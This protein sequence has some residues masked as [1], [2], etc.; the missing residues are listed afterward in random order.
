MS[1]TVALVLAVIVTAAAGAADPPGGAP[2]FGLPADLRLDLSPDGTAVGAG[3]DAEWAG[4]RLRLS[5]PAGSERTGSLEREL[6]DVL[7]EAGC[8]AP[9]IATAA[10]LVS[11][12]Q[13]QRRAGRLARDSIVITTVVTHVLKA[14]IDSPRPNRPEITNG[15][16]SGHASMTFAFARSVAEEDRDWGAAAY[17][18]AAGVAWSRVRRGDHDIPQVLAGAALGWWIADE[19]ARR[20]RPATAP[21]AGGAPSGA[22]AEVRW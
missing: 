20:H 6:A 14:T 8:V 4:T 9:A 22:P 7:S 17:A 16:P 3:P 13:W 2:A 15:F 1:R 12:E 5:A 21:L 10:M 18:W 19:V 11:D